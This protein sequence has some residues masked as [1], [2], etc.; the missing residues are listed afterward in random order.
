MDTQ[1][2]RI[3]PDLTTHPAASTESVLIAPRVAP[4]P[5]NMTKKR[6][7]LFMRLI[8]LI[9]ILIALVLL[10]II[11]FKW[12]PLPTTSFML[13]SE[14]KPVQ[15]SWVPASRISNFARRA[16]IAAEDQKFPTHNGFD[17]EAMEKAYAH[18]KKSKHKRGA[19]TISQQTA[20]NLFLW[21]GGGYFRKGV[22]AGITVL[23]E[24][25]W[26]KDRI[27]E[28]YLNVV[29]FGPGLYGV[30]A[31]SQIYFHK[32]ASDLTPTEAA[33]LAAV[34]PNPTH[35]KVNAPG[36][37]VQ[38][39]VSWI[40]GQMGYGSRSAPSEEPEPPTTGPESG[41]QL[42]DVD[43]GASPVPSAAATPAPAGTIEE[44]A[45]IA[46]PVPVAPEPDT[47]AAPTP[48]PSSTP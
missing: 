37:Y 24:N 12:V 31:A 18:N 27:L 20:K 6:T 28:V 3:D 17:V 48:V 9:V 10:P 29:E 33:R 16:V 19:S 8:Q 40:V 21:S 13:Q 26:G 1:Q 43:Y 41:G 44:P 42:N 34:L 4:P 39:R 5:E 11:L 36:A 15:Y 25:I 7:S 30:E 47:S 46:E 14:V 35:W 23:I 32:H 22:E 38:R 45:P 2:P